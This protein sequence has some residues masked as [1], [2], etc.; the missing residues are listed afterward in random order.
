ML[1]RHSCG[2]GREKW[3]LLFPYNGRSTG[4]HRNHWIRRDLM[5]NSLVCFYW[6]FSSFSWLRFYLTPTFAFPIE[7]PLH[8]GS[9][10]E[11]YTRR[12]GRFGVT[13]FRNACFRGYG[14]CALQGNNCCRL[15][16]SRQIATGEEIVQVCDLFVYASLSMTCTRAT[17]WNIK[18]LSWH[19]VPF[20]LNAHREL[21]ELDIGT[22]ESKT[23]QMVNLGIVLINLGDLHS[24]L[25]IMER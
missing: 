24:A 12:Q 16:P 15:L 6:E 1:W 21:V 17:Y 22:E 8:E 14:W 13:R 5:G 19:F 10:P 23:V 7:A 9:S 3:K 25:E 2:N 20:L 11:A 18:P 4:P